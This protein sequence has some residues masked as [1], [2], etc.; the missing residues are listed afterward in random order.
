MPVSGEKMDRW[1]VCGRLPAG[2]RLWC[3]APG[4]GIPQPMKRGG[5]PPEIL[6]TNDL[7]GCF[8]DLA[9]PWFAAREAL[10][11][12]ESPFLCLSGGDEHGG[13]S[14]WDV[15]HPMGTDPSLPFAWQKA[16]GIHAAV[17][18]N[19]D[20]DWG[21]EAYG[22][23]IQ[24]QPTIPRVLS[25]LR[26]ESPLAGLH[27]PAL[28]LEWPHHLMALLGAL[29]VED[30]TQ[31]EEHLLPPGPPLA[32]LIGELA[33][34]VDSLVI[35]SHLGWAR[36][37]GVFC[38]PALLPTL[39]PHALLLGAHSH[40]R[41][42]SDDR[43]TP[44]AYL[45]CAPNAGSIGRA[46]WQN[47]Q[48]TVRNLTASPQLPEFAG[49]V[50]AG[51]PAPARHLLER[52]Q[53]IVAAIGP[54]HVPE[55]P[56]A[57]ES[58]AKDGY[59][60]E[61]AHFNAVTDI[62]AELTHTASP[63]LAALCVRAMTPEPVTGT[64]NA[65]DWYRRFGYADR[66]FVLDLP[67]NTLWALLRENAQR[68]LMPA[69]FIANRGFL[70]FSAD[71]RYSI[72]FVEDSEPVIRSVMLA[73]DPLEPDRSPPLRIAT[74]AYVATGQGG[75]AD[76]FRRCGIPL[77]GRPHPV[78]SGPVRDLLWHAFRETEPAA[79]AG[80]FRVDG[81]LRQQKPNHA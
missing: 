33:P 48:W 13:T 55:H 72:D 57:T 27:A 2:G 67:A 8:E 24:A 38:D 18:G 79:L 69:R 42:P 64:L 41:L 59:R 20:L 7:H 77:K 68:L 25:H 43:W 34:H 26:P 40:T 44:K 39:P 32:A 78:T 23:M 53:S 63:H 58:P 61:S 80:R 19:H 1:K 81:R 9:K 52:R 71:L 6:Y 46:S 65:A 75:Y 54:L 73:G 36:R 28:L 10:E 30:T 21:W 47:G 17:P 3:P 62:L 74:H 31:G 12:K 15:A 11:K 35:L 66:C 45:Q 76:I 56:F 37:D 22:R 51:W 50:T 5:P 16:L 4:T 60:G 49:P 70:H 29:T 14:P